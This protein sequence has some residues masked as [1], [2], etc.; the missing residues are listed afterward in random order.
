[1]NIKAT[2][3]IS[4]S[5]CTTY[6]EV[7]YRR[8]SEAE[9][10]WTI[11]YPNPVSAPIVLENLL[12]DDVYIAEVVRVCCDSGKSLTATVSFETPIYLIPPYGLTAT[13]ISMSEVRFDWQAVAGAAGYVIQWY[14]S[15]DDGPDNFAG[16]NEAVLT[17][18]GKIIPT[19]E[20]GT[21]TRYRVKAT[22]PGSPDSLWSDTYNNTNP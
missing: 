21:R 9:D 17:T 12:P 16:A 22:H 7:R 19:P 11:V 14:S 6:F 4:D 20:S 5:P 10:N 3:P 1:M 15:N 13:T 18:N 2:I 8:A